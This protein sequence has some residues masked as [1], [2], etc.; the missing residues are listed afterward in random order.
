MVVPAVFH[1]SSMKQES[2][3]SPLVVSEPSRQL[4]LSPALIMRQPAQEATRHHYGLQCS[5]TVI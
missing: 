1:D 4:K 3:E 5:I 2:A